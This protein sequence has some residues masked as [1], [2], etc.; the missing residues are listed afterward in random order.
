MAISIFII[1]LASYANSLIV[2]IP[3]WIRVETISHHSESVR[4]TGIIAPQISTVHE[5]VIVPFQL[6]A[7]LSDPP[8]AATT[9]PTS[10]PTPTA[11]ATMILNPPVLIS[12][13]VI[14]QDFNLC[15]LR[16]HQPR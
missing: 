16:S 14:P 15:C 7:A 6:P 5:E 10:T 2:P 12:T 1:A 3:S 8:I 13:P 11:V 9:N 4:D